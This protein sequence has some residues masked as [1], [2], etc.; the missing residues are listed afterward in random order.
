MDMYNYW[1]IYEGKGLPK[2]CPVCSY[3]QGYYMHLKIHNLKLER[4]KKMNKS[5][6]LESSVDRNYGELSNSEEC[7]CAIIG[8]GIAGLTTAYLLAKEGKEVKLVDANKIGY[9]C[10]GKNTGK[11]TTQHNIIYSKIKKKIWIG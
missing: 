11:I 8:G 3:P 7:N 4:N 9:G 1:F 10:T 6:W 5:Y 2:F